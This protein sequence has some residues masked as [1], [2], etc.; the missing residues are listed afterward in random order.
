M[1]TPKDDFATAG[2]EPLKVAWSYRTGIVKRIAHLL[3]DSLRSTFPC[4]RDSKRKHQQTFT[5]QDKMEEVGCHFFHR[6]VRQQGQSNQ[7]QLL[8]G[9]VHKIEMSKCR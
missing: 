3:K 5:E 7:H 9:I 4:G 6:Y 2:R 8:A 1:P